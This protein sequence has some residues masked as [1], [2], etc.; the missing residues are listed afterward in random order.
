[1]QV[2]FTIPL[3]SKFLMHYI[4]SHDGMATLFAAVI[5]SAEVNFHLLLDIFYVDVLCNITVQSVLFCKI[6]LKL[7]NVELSFIEDSVG[8]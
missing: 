7:S 3:P 6:L 4:N 5:R 8:L 2:T 1:M